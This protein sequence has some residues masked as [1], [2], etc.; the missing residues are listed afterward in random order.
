MK[1]VDKPWGRELWWAVTGRYVGKVLEVRSGHALSLQYHREKLESM[2]FWSGTGV[3]T[4]GEGQRRV[5]PG[6]C[7]TIEPGTPHRI[8]AES[9]MV[10]LEVSTPQVEDV[11]RLED[12]YGRTGEVGRDAGV[13]AGRDPG[14][15]EGG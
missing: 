9:D 6:E 13:T 3:L 10:I 4:L 11:V 8:E 14:G 1:V 5:G 7:V 2:M 15:A 12:R